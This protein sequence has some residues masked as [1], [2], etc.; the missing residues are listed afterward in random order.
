MKNDEFRAR[1]HELVDWM[2]DY[3]EDESYKV[4]PPTLP[5]EVRDQFPTTAPEDAENFDAIFRDFQQTIVPNMTHWNHPGWFAYFPAN[6]SPPSV[7]AEMLTATLGAQCMSWQTS[8]AAT[9]LEQVVMSWLQQAC[10]LPEHF[11]GVIHDTA[12]TGTLVALITAR[13]KVR[14][15]HPNASMRVYTSSEAHSSIDKAVKMAGFG[16]ENLVR[17]AVDEHLAMR[18]DA[19]LHA[20]EQDIIQ[21]HTPAAV[22]ATIG[23]TSTTAIDPIYDIGKICREHGIWFH[24]DAAYAGTAALLPEFRWM[25]DG[26]EFADSYVFNP[27]KWML[28]NFDC[29][30]YFVA[31]PAT[32]VETFQTSPEYLKTQFDAEVPNFRDWGIQLGRRFRALKLWFVMRA[33]GLEGI[34]TMLRHHIALADGLRIQVVESPRFELMAEGRLG[35]VVLRAAPDSVPNN[36]LDDLNAALLAKLNAEG[37]VY[38]THT[39]VTG[40]YAIRVSIGQWRT[41]KR[42]VDALWTSL[43][44][45]LDDVLRHST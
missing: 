28:T 38:A 18:P 40:R 5:G 34:R 30:A 44:R 2:A 6:N 20:I 7:L 17:I 22:C 9:E 32:L 26:L 33:Y 29:T 37:H 4:A 42:H 35:L 8:P 14:A 10:G 12:S 3:F 16:L 24:V 27:H 41:E 23:T 21:G 36:E 15:T 45:I 11:R 43:N 19:L 39:R 31:D 1:A 25:F 13:E